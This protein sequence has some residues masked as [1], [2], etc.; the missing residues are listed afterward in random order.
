MAKLA[1]I[2]AV[3]SLLATCLQ[4][5]SIN[6]YKEDEISGSGYDKE[7]N[8]EPSESGDDK[9]RN[10]GLSG[11][12]YI[13][14][15]SGYIK[16]GSGYK[17]GNEEQPDNSD[18]EDYNTSESG[19]GLRI[20]EQIWKKLEEQLKRWLSLNILSKTTNHQNTS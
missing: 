15:G 1:I 17:A 13:K 19:S 7:R 4:A 18:D 2:L 9:E 14:T 3:L 16:T 10:E 5:K 20:E 6:I 12:G 8:E 11:S